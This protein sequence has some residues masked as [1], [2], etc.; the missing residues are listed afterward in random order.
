MVEE[1][2]SDLQAA[3]ALQ[4]ESSRV[5]IARCGARI[6]QRAGV[7]VDAQKQQGGLNGIQHAIAFLQALHKQGRSGANLFRS[8]GPVCWETITGR[9]VVDHPDLRVCPHALDADQRLGVHQGDRLDLGGRQVAR[10]DER[11]LNTVK[12]DEGAHVAVH[13]PRRDG[14]GALVDQ[15]SSEQGGYGVK[16]GLFVGQDDAHRYTSVLHRM[17]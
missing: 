14:D 4:Q 7:L 11:Q 12:G 1:V 8:K 15:V 2:G 10:I 13:A 6:G 16:I 5:Q 17:D 3:A 9:V